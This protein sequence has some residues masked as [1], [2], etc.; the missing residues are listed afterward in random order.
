MASGIGG[1]L[2]W[3]I[4]VVIAIVIQKIYVKPAKYNLSLMQSLSGISISFI[5]FYAIFKSSSYLIS[6]NI[7]D[8]EWYRLL[9]ML[10]TPLV[11]SFTVFKGWIFKNGLFKNALYIPNQNIALSLL[12]ITYTFPGTQLTYLAYMLLLKNI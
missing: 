7:L 3:L 8:Y 4:A 6:Q 9:W 10:F 11:I 1:T 5:I 12:L 2:F